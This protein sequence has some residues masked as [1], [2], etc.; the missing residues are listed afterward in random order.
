MSTIILYYSNFCSHSNKLINEIMRGLNKKGDKL[1]Y[2][3]IDNQCISENKV[4]VKLKNQQLLTLPSIIN[5]T[6]S[7]LLLTQGLKV[8]R[9]YSE[10]V[11]YFNGMP[12]SLSPNINFNLEQEPNKKKNI[13]L[14]N[15]RAPLSQSVG[16][17]PMGQELFDS[18]S[19]PFTNN[20]ELNDINGVDNYTNLNNHEPIYTPKD[21]YEYNKSTNKS[22]EELQKEREMSLK[23]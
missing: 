20:L 7:L 22:I 8:I 11:N 9:G 19:S 21:N 16:Q 15:Q 18:F 5:C 1:L 2:I 10:I 14:I 17:P 23:N 6:P 13:D 4:M 12:S 3:N